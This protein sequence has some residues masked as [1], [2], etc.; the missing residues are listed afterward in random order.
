M[1][2]HHCENPTNSYSRFLDKPRLNKTLGVRLGARSQKSAKRQR[3]FK[4]LVEKSGLTNLTVIMAPA[5]SLFV[6][7]NELTDWGKTLRDKRE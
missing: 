1:S 7:A 6:S 2:I 4:T 3:A 5:I